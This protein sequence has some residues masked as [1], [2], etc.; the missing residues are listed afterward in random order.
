MYRGI[1]VDAHS[2]EV[3]YFKPDAGSA[4]RVNKALDYARPRSPTS[5]A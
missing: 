2:G 5:G 1:Y 4:I 3:T